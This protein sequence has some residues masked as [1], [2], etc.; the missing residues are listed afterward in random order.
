MIGQPIKVFHYL[1]SYK[2]NSTCFVD[3]I[4]MLAKTVDIICTRF[5]MQS[6]SKLLKDKQRVTVELY[7]WL[8]AEVANLGFDLNINA[9][10]GEENELLGL[11]FS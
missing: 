10:K 6:S 7:D 2:R 8:E 11:F 4:S 9:Y 3:E 5:G 1:I